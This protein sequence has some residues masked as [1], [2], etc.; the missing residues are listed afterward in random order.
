VDASFVTHDNF[1]GYTEATM[2][3]GRGSV[4]G[5]S[6]KQKIN[7][8]SST[9]LELVGADNAIPQMTWTRYFLEAQGCNVEE[10]ILNQYNLSAML[11]ETNGNQSIRERIKH[12]RVRYF[13]IK[14]RVSNGD[15]TLKHCPVGE[16]LADHFIKPLQGVLFCKLQSDIQGTPV[17]INEAELGWDR[18]EKSER[19][20]KTNPRPQECVGLKG[21]I[22]RSKDLGLRGR[23]LLALQKKIRPSES[24]LKADTR[25]AAF[26]KKSVRCSKSAS[27]AHAVKGL[28][29]GSRP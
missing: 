15:I 28:R 20:K 13:F 11:L 7:T 12:I 10:C 23:Y 27:Y 3:L 4:I 18:E 6:K 25:A 16:M 19:V 5:L 2:S 26:R 8:Q 9:E 1:Q 22:Y 24:V 14:D 17:D 29:T 21:K